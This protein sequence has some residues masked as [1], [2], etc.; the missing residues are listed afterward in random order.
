MEP[1]KKV[2]KPTEA[3]TQVKSTPEGIQTSMTFDQ[4]REQQGIPGPEEPLSLENAGRAIDLRR[5]LRQQLSL[6]D[7]SNQETG[8]SSD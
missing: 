8:S 4:A 2:A 3:P 5:A 7:K 6:M 1:E